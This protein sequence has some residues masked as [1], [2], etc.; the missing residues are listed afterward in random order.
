M[1]FRTVNVQL[2]DH[3]LLVIVGRIVNVVIDVILII[4]HLKTF[5]NKFEEN[6]Q[7]FRRRRGDENVRIAE[8]TETNVFASPRVSSFIRFYPKAIAPATAKPNEADFPRPRDA[9]IEQ[10][11]R[12]ALS[13]IVSNSFSRTLP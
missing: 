9:V 12:N 3:F 8:K 2:N 5:E 4:Q 6:L 10:V 11:C 7:I 1:L 13:V